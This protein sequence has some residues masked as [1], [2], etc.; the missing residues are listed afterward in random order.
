[1]LT[2]DNPAAGITDYSMSADSAHV[3]L[4][5]SAC[6]ASAERSDPRFE[7]ALQFERA[8]KRAAARIDGW[9]RDSDSLADDDLESPT[10]ACLARASQMIDRLKAKVMDRVLPTD[11]A[12]LCFKGASL[13][14]AGE[15]SFELGSGPIAVTYRIEPDGS[16]TQLFFYNNKLIRREQFTG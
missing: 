4:V 1:M 8:L 16:I 7:W 9:S 6:G 5:P 15:I 3:A 14:S 13:G 12:M 10:R 2:L 11:E